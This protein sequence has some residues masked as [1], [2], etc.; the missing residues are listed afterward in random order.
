VLFQFDAKHG[1]WSGGSAVAAAF[2]KTLDP[3]AGYATTNYVIADMTTVPQTWNTYGVS[4][5]ITPAL[6]GQLLQAG[7]VS[8]AT[9]YDP[10]V[11]FY[12]NILF[13]PDQATPTAGVSW[14]R[15][16]SLYGR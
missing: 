5:A 6:A 7:F 2:I 16:K 9:H 8:T 15:I 10:S 14:G 1:N 3:A 11:V 13:A 12:N 4:L